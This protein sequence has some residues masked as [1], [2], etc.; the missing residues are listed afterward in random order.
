MDL[1]KDSNIVS[2]RQMEN[3]LYSIET[4]DKLLTKEMVNKLTDIILFI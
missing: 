2:E 1:E 4:E 3:G